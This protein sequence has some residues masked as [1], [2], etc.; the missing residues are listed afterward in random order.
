M[1]PESV[2]MLSSASLFASAFLIPLIMQREFGVNEAEIGVV[3]AAYAAALFLSSMAFGRLADVRG[4]RKILQVGL[5]VCT[6][7]SA[8]QFFAYDSASLLVVR[9]IMG[10]AAGTFPASLMAY[11]YE[12]H[13]K[14]GKFASYGA[15]GW[16]VGTM[17]AGV[18]A[19]YS[20]FAPF[21]VSTA[22]FGIAFAISLTLPFPKQTLLKIPLFPI[23]VIKRNGASYAGMLLRHTGACMIWVIYPIFLSRINDSA[24]WIGI[25]YAINAGT[26]FVVMQLLDKYDGRKLFVAGLLLSALTFFMF[27]ISDNEWMIMADQVVLGCSWACTYVGALKI[28]LAK[29]AERSTS[30]G[31]LDSTLSL[32]TIIGSL[33]GGLVAMAFG[34]YMTMW[35]AAG[36]SLAGLVIFLAMSNGR[37]AASAQT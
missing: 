21:L 13:G 6:L 4:R 14:A 23:N 32:S 17:L 34:E 29:G 16:G 30:S 36:L 31:L 12:S 20:L 26:Q 8:V 9:V 15:L 22:L 24:I 7:T 18:F 37:A 27:I 1:K 33:A 25:V 2:Q 3:V 19:A 35:V 10:F 28:I 5:L 11:A